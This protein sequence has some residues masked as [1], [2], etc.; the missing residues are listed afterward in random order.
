MVA[1]PLVTP[2]TIP[3]D[4]PIVATAVLE[5]DHTPPDVVLVRVVLSLAQIRSVPPI[6]AG[7]E[8]TVTVTALTHPLDKLYEIVAVPA[9][10]P[11]T[12]PFVPTVAVAV[13]LLLQVPPVDAV[14]NVVV[15]P[16]QTES[17]P[18]ILAGN[19]LVVNVCVE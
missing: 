14:L 6:A 15:L 10:T 8:F 13:L 1:V 5:L 17:A 19:G 4:V 3:V 9:A 18:V 16:S 7:N 11:L 2:V 12:T